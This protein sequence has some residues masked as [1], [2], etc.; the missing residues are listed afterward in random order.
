M[1]R[2]YTAS[3]EEVKSLRNNNKRPFFVFLL[4]SLLLFTLIFIFPLATLII[5]SFCDWKVAGIPEFS[6]IKNY[7]MLF[8]QDPFFFP[9]LLNN[10]KWILLQTT[11]HV[12]IA[13]LVALTLSKK[14][15]YWKFARTIYMV[16]NFVAGA[17]IGLMFMCLLNPQFGLVNVILRF[18]TGNPD[19]QQ[20]WFMDR[21]TAF[22][23]VTSTWL[24]YAGTSMLL[25]LTEITSI[26]RDLFEAAYVDGADELQ[27]S[28]YIVLPLLRNIIGTCTI[29]GATSMLQRLDIIQLTTKG[30]PGHATMNLP[31]FIYQRGMMENNY[32]LANA[33]GTMLLLL[34]ICV[35]GIIT[36]IYKVGD[37]NR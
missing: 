23:S 15:F 24:F 37:T 16:P 9:A 34:G 35:V 30:G 17:A 31:I 21:N 5:T 4:P 33:A 12:L 11:V 36:R 28:I 22:G 14:P 25:I 32:G 13:L 2:E 7:I 26:D 20:Y 19:F 6:G 1:P 3:K 18:I 29:L 10:L 27:M 8:T